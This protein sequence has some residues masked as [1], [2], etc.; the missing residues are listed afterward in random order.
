MKVFIYDIRTSSISEVSL[1][2]EVS[3]VELKYALSYFSRKKSN[4]SRVR[5]LNYVLS[6]DRNE[7]LR[8]VS[9]LFSGI[10]KENS[11]RRLRT[12]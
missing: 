9:S 11:A 12:I 10:A 2:D 3:S 1:G 7:L 4:P 6:L 5:T 8:P